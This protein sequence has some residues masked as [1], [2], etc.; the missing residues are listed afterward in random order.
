MAFRHDDD[1]LQITCTHPT[2][3]KV[4]ELINSRG[5]TAVGANVIAGGLIG[6]AIDH[7]SGAGYQYPTNLSIWFPIIGAPA[8][9][10]VATQSA[11]PYTTPSQNLNAAFRKNYSPT[12]VQR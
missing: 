1:P 2:L 11:N 7:T 8:P 6:A 5:S 4:N 10:I 3:G 12:L 9:T